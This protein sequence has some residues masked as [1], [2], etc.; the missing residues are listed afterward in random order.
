MTPW[1]WS[2]SSP[3]AIQY[4]IRLN[5]AVGLAETLNKVLSNFQILVAHG[6]L[7][8]PC[9]CTQMFRSMVPQLAGF[10]VTI[11]KPRTHI[12]IYTLC[13]YIYIYIYIH[14]NIYTYIYIYTYTYI[15]IHIYIYMYI[16]IC[17]FRHPLLNP[18]ASSASSRRSRPCLAQA[19]QDGRLQ[20][21]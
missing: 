6:G 14:I 12:D 15:Y 1:S 2:L 4:T 11:I 9:A 13:I 3:A 8:I 5:G 20:P 10:K 19:G 17:S 21:S 16:Y 18:P 7:T